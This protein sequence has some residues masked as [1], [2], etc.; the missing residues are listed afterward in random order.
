MRLC[1]PLSP[2]DRVSK[3]AR[4]RRASCHSL[5]QTT[6]PT[7]RIDMSGFANG[8]SQEEVGRLPVA[9]SPDKHSSRA[10]R[11]Q[12]LRQPRR[13]LSRFGLLDE[14]SISNLTKSRGRTI[15]ILSPNKEPTNSK[16][17]LIGD[18]HEDHRLGGAFGGSASLMAAVNNGWAFAALVLVLG[19]WLC[20]R[21]EG[22]AKD[23]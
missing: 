4:G 13:G 7:L 17:L 2:V 5:R 23:D 14:T 15:R 18:F 12:A 9:P 3:V 19:V 10:I 22:K 16:F 1:H 8:M 20:V 11:Q 21:H 6:L